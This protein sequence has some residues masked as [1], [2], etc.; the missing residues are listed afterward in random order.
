MDFYKKYGHMV[1]C[2]GLYTCGFSVDHMLGV[3]ETDVTT[4]CKLCDCDMICECIY[5]KTFLIRLPNSWTAR[6]RDRICNQINS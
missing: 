2:F 1:S 5:A 4:R 6:H 3:P